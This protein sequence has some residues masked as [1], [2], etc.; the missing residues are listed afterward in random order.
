MARV[1]LTASGVAEGT[2]HPKLKRATI[3]FILMNRKD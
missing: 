2:T 3:L 1:Q